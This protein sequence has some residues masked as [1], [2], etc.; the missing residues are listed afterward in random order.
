MKNGVIEMEQVYS[1]IVEFLEEEL[2]GDTSG[3]SLDHALRVY[4]NA[5]A[6]LKEEGG[7]E[8]IVLISAL[9]HDVIDPK[10]FKN[11]HEQQAKLLMFLQMIGCN[12]VELEQI[13][14]IIE[15]ISYKGGN[16]KP[17]QT[18]E[19]KI[20]QDADRLDAIGAIGIGRTFMYGGVKGSKMYDENISIMNFENEVVYRQHQGTVINHFYEKLFKLKDLM[21]TETAKQL[22]N[23]RHEF[24]VL[25]VEQFLNEWNGQL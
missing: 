25:F 20:V 18:I 15:N 3:H 1:H 16:G 11:P 2:G 19:A 13:F 23:K 22:A 5:K 9:V 24:M 12:Q 14:Y 7:N 8:R 10:L 17:V 21:N 4:K 6:I